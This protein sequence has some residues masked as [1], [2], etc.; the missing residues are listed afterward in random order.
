M[1]CSSVTMKRVTHGGQRTGAGR[2]PSDPT[3][4]ITFRVKLEHEQPVRDAVKK[5]VAEL[6]KKQYVYKPK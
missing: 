6:N 4:I 5:T 1:A 2:K 3:K